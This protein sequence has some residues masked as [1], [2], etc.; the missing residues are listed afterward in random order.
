MDIVKEWPS[1]HFYFTDPDG[2]LY[3]FDS[4]GEVLEFVSKFID[5]SMCRTSDEND[6]QWR[7]RIQSHLIEMGNIGIAGAKA[8]QKLR[9]EYEREPIK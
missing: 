2:K 5:I 3:L 8:G 1:S 4:E 7:Y 9:R 6:E